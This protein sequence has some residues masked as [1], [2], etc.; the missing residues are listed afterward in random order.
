L[1]AIQAIVTRVFTLKSVGDEAQAFEHLADLSLV[2]GKPS[3]HVTLSREHDQALEQETAA[4]G[5]SLESEDVEDL[6]D[7][8]GDG[9]AHKFLVLL[10]GQGD[11]S[12]R[13]AKE[14]PSHRG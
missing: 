6:G 14:I 1:V 10:G 8:L 12:A 11:Q 13:L 9:E 4:V 2:Q 3:A 5:V 7:G